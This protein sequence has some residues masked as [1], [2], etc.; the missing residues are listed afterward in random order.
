MSD[1]EPTGQAPD[2]TQDAD[3]QEPDAD[4]QPQNPWGDDFDADKAWTL[5][6]NLRSEVDE[7]KAERKAA[8]DEA[9]AATRKAQEAEEAKLAENEQYRE[10]ADKRAERLLELEPL[11]PRIKEVEA[12]RDQYR[13]ALQ[14]HVDAM[15][16]DIPEHVRELLTGKSPIE[17]LAWLDKHGESFRKSGATGVPDTPSPNGEHKMSDEEKRRLAAMPGRDY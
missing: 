10:L 15:T 6:Q 17:T 9:A 14:S 12:E 4:A 13:D 1:N 8:K 16:K 3:G 7:M 2:S 5:V 11:E